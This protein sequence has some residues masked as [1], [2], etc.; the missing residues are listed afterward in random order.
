MTVYAPSDFNAVS[1]PV[2]AGGCGQTHG[3][4]DRAPG[5]HLA[6]DCEKCEPILLSMAGHGW[7]SDPLHVA[8]TPDEQRASE[9]MATKAAMEQQ[10][11]WSSPQA[12]AAFMHAAGFN[13]AGAEDGG[14]AAQEMLRMMR[15]MQDTMQQ[16][17]AEIERL[18]AANDGQPTPPAA[19]PAK[20][21]AAKK[22]APAAGKTAE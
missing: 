6:V 22:A 5:E 14:A 20:K 18:K 10:K 1:V 13:Q 21:A 17:Q 12:F 3:G 2:D 11:T 19:T 9:A 15:E 4:G 16:Q 7:A 8:L